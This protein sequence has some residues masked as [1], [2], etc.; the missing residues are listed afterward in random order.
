MGPDFALRNQI[1]KWVHDSPFGS[2]SGEDATLKMLKSLFCWRGMTKVVQAYVRQCVICQSCK[3]D[4]SPN[5]GL[6]QAI[7]IPKE[8]WVDVSMDF[9]E[10]LPKFYGK[11]VI[12][13]VVDRFNK[14]AHFATLSHPFSAIDVAQTYLDHVFKLH[15]WPQS[16]I[17]DRDRVFSSDFWQVLLSIQGTTLLMSTT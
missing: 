13:V 7:Q 8:V 3:Y 4:T 12:F 2:H 1:F 6:L 17:S 14:Y 15:G 10:G 16:I 11:E 5:L 9:I